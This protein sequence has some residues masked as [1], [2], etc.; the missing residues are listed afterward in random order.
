MMCKFILTMK[1][2][3]KRKKKKGKKK[4]SDAIWFSQMPLISTQA[5]PKND[6][7]TMQVTDIL[8][9]LQ[10]QKLIQIMAT[11]WN[12]PN[13]LPWKVNL[14]SPPYIPID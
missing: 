9:Y 10:Q 6:I 8:R 4:L 1:M 14:H 13:K 2:Q 5:G 12:T 3:L 11:L 7:T